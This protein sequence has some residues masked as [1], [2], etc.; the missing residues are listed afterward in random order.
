VNAALPEQVPTDSSARPPAILRFLS[1]P[2]TR[3]D[4][5]ASGVAVPTNE[6]SGATLIRFTRAVPIWVVNWLTMPGVGHSIETL[7]L[8]DRISRPLRL[9]FSFDDRVPA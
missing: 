8:S 2:R 9:T 1:V 5:E 4:V 3:I 6:P 7:T